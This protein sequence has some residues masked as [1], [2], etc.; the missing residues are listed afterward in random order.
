ML[1]VFQPHGLLLLLQQV[2]LQLVPPHDV[3]YCLVLLHAFKLNNELGHH[4]LFIIQ[5]LLT[6]GQLLLQLTCFKFKHCVELCC[7]CLQL[8]LRFSDNTIN[9]C[10]Q[11]LV[12][13]LHQFELRDLF[14]QP[15]HFTLQQ[16]NLL[17]VLTNDVL[18]LELLNPELEFL[19][20]HLCF[21][22]LKLS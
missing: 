16:L 15:F 18:K 13:C 2:H 11:L 8:R 3:I 17:L 9:F 5:L 20:V 12:L 19:L 4:L 22:L 7:L 10:L 1:L 6:Q 14:F 21:Q